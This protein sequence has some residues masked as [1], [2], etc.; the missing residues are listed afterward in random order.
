MEQANTVEEYKKLLMRYN[1]YE[2]VFYRGQSGEYS[3]ITSSIS[4]DAGFTT[5]ENLIYSDA[6]NLGKNELLDQEYPIER[7]SIMQHYGIPTRLVDF[8]IDP[9]TALFFAVQND[10]REFYGNVYIFIQTKYSLNDKRIKLLALLATMNSL[11]ICAIQNSYQEYYSESISEDEIFEF[12]AKGAFIEHSEELQKTNK[13]LFCQKGTFAICGNEV[14]KEEI[15]KTILPLDSIEPTMVIRIPS[16]HKQ[17]VK[18]ELDRIYGINETIIYPEFSSIANYLKEKY[19]K[20]DFQLDGTYRI[21]EEDDCSHAGA[22]RI[23]IVAVLNKALLIEEIKQIGIQIIELHK[24]TS[25]VVWVFIAKDEDA[26]IMRNWLMR[27]Q[28]INESLDPRFKPHAIGDKDKSGYIWSFEKSYSTLAEY[29]NEH[30]FECDKIL[31]IENM[32]TFEEFQTHYKY[33]A[34][35]LKRENIKELESYALNNAS[36]IS[37]YF[38]RFGEFGYSRNGD[39]NKYLSNFQELAL[40]LD[41]VVIWLKKEDLNPRAKKYHISS[42]FENAKLCFDRINEQAEHWK[43]SIGISNDEYNKID[44][45]KIFRKEYQYKQTIPINQKGLAVSFNLNISPN[46]DNTVSIKGTTNL[47]DKASLMISITDS[48]DQ[49]LGQNKAS[50]EN[51]CFDF[52]RLGKKGVGYGKGEYRIEI[53]LSLPSTQDK[54]FVSK[55]GIEYEN[56]VG[57]YVDRS[58]VGPTVRYTQRFEI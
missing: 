54:D 50:V 6:L 12:A 21:L 42:C 39:F 34:R 17:A 14:L 22:R 43:N 35:A 46:S 32:K 9:L 28:W 49:L 57:E 38:L 11:E 48:K 52:G 19:K 56:L 40:H 25:D 53:T 41:N 5:N 29:Y 13:R 23:S 44:P 8:T 27:G 26:Y 1:I 7:L 4:R 31:Y 15:K 33:M 16:E 3:N 18:K 24:S 45:S 20:C 10:N 36:T 2:N 47:F 37:D 58:G 30:V 55:A 51:G